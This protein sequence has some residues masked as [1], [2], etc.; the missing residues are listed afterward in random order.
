[1]AYSFVG[2]RTREPIDLVSIRREAS[3]LVRPMPATVM[4]MPPEVR[5]FLRNDN[6]VAY[7]DADHRTAPRTQVGLVRRIRLDRSDGQ[8]GQPKKPHRI[9]TIDT[10]MAAPTIA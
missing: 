3:R 10:T 5:S 7:S 2:C 4:P 9:A 1:M 6:Q 8:G